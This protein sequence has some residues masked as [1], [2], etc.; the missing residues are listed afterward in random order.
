MDDLKFHP[1]ESPKNTE[2]LSVGQWL[3][4]LLL[5]MIP[6][7]NIVLLCVWAFSGDNSINLNK[8]NLSRAYL[9]LM[10]CVTGLYIVLL[11]VIFGLVALFSAS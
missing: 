6:I 2:P 11:I 10:G 5:L 1:V 9:I 8:R 4:T 7:A 3:I